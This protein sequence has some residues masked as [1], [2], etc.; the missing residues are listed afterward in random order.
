MARNLSNKTR[1]EADDERSDSVGGR[2]A[3]FR[4][5]RGW[6]QSE[7]AEKIGVSQALLSAYELGKARISADLVVQAAQALRVPLDVLLGVKSA[8][9]PEPLQGR[10][11]LRRLARFDALPRRKQDAL[12]HTIDAVL[13]TA[14]A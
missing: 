2:I 14:E 5:E 12:L 9:A 1:A 8:P 3:R 7:L 13:E 11:L 4:K 6:S 10:R